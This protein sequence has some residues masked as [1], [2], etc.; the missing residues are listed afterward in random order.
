L[1]G[2]EIGEVKRPALHDSLPAR[3]ASDLETNR[4]K[5]KLIDVHGDSLAFTERIAMPISLPVRAPIVTPA[6]EQ[7]SQTPASGALK[8]QQ[9]TDLGNPKA[10]PGQGANSTIAQRLNAQLANNASGIH[11]L[12]T[13]LKLVILS[14]L[15]RRADLDGMR[16]SGSAGYALASLQ[17]IPIKISNAK[18]L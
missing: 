5:M 12:P 8:V 14:M 3:L 10:T 4:N 16:L 2:K 18:E 11:S 17:P 9:S 15:A 13:E 1:P 6:S 7:A